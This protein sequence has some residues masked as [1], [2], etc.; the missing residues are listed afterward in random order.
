MYPSLLQ[1]GTMTMLTAIH[2]E[3]ICHL[4]DRTLYVVFKLSMTNTSLY[5]TPFFPTKM[6]FKS[7]YVFRLLGCFK[8]GCP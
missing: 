1:M 5:T 8:Y 3:N 4:E 7:Y 6:D 2:F